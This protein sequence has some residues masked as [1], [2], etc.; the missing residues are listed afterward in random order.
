MITQSFTNLRLYY[1]VKSNFSYLN[2]AV[3]ILLLIIFTFNALY[4][5]SIKSVYNMQ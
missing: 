3:Y 4:A 2:V 5:K 1:E